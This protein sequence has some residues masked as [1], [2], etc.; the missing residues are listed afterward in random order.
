MTMEQPHADHHAIKRALIDLCYERGFAELPVDEV[1]RRAEVQRAVFD[2]RYADLEDCFTEAY[3]ELADEFL[4]RV[5][6]AYESEGTWR[7]QLRAAS[8]ATMRH[9]EEDSARA[10]FTVIEALQAGEKVQL[11]RERVFTTL[12]SMI[13]RGRDEPDARGS[14]T[15]TTAEALN[16]A[17]FR[18]MRLALE[19][20][21][22][23]RLADVL[24]E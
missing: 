23:H 15:T 10:H 8:Y 11:V 7:E 13:D 22:T 16:G 19:H 17:V 6:A 20:D 3:A 2:A 4:D 12:G 21:Q 5:T 24:P 18:H 9:L 14:L 1:C